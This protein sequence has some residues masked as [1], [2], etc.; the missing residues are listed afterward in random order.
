MN[1]QDKDILKTQLLTDPAEPIPEQADY[2]R[3]YEAQNE[4]IRHL[5][6]VISA[7][8]MQPV[9]DHPLKDAKPAST[10]A[11]VRAQWGAV[12]FLNATRAEKLTALGVDPNGVDDN[13]LQKG[14][15]RGNDG[16]VAGELMRMSPLRYRQ[17]KESA[18]I[19]GIYAA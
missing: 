16:K 1:E 18:I 11:Q 14:F 8:R 3:L 13:L 7:G 10:A 19:L 9:T 2:K 12:R 15:G 17:L 4:R 6:D 5:E